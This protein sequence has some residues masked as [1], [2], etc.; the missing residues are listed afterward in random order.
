MYYLCCAHL[1]LDEGSMLLEKSAEKQGKVLDE[2]LFIIM[3]IFVGLSD[4]STQGQHL[5][6]EEEEGERGGEGDREVKTKVR[7]RLLSYLPV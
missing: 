6:E 5:R 4:I 7:R 1:L 2:V 3:A